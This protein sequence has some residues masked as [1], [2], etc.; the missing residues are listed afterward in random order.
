[1]KLSSRGAY[2]IAVIGGGPAGATAARLLAEWG[3]RVALLARPPERRSLAE[4][5]PPSTRKILDHV[6]I[7]KRVE[8][9]GFLPATGN[10]AWWGDSRGHS[11]TFEDATGF[12]VLRA[13]FDR[14]LIDAAAKAGVTRL[15][16]TV[17]RVDLAAR[18]DVSVAYRVGRAP[19]RLRARCVLD[20]SGRAGVI[21]RRFR[22][23]DRRL[24][25]VAL[26]GVWV[27]EAGFAGTAPGHTLV[28]A[29]ADGWAWSVP[30]SKQRRHVALMI[31]PRPGARY[32]AE[33]AKTA[34]VKRA[35]AGAAL[36]GTPWTC[37]ASVYGAKAF[38]GE[39]FLLVGDAGSFLDPMSSFGVKKALASAWMAAVVANTCLT[40]PEH[41]AAAIAL[42]EQREQEMAATY[43]QESAR[44]NADAAARFGTAFWE[45]RLE[46]SSRGSADD[47]ELRA[48]FERL[49][50]SRA[51]SLRLAPGVELGR[52]PE[53]RGREVVLEDGL[54]SPALSAPVRYVRGVELPRLVRLAPEHG[55]VLQ[56]LEAYNRGV[57]RVA[58]PEL[59]GALSFAIAK[60]VL[61]WVP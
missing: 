19:K 1:M 9:A 32:H 25:T 43:A 42:F 2:D 53:V 45:R 50:T 44:Y 52:A 23:K 20:C 48:A 38:G 31:D 51:L 13:D 27:R 54:L 37:D 59:L 39:R 56:L 41:G 47:S 3:H 55:D 61:H 40:R 24:T 49:R 8:R 26:S 34:H 29:Y 28:E 46:A 33:L 4:S 35:L 18:E 17:T 57:A 14:L 15:D 22:V 30:L 36:E 12:Q 5:L 16:A 21:A 58:L 7:L 6:G 11:E 10:T 60:R